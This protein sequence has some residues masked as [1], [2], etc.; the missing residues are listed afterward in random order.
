LIPNLI[1]AA[2][3]AMV[4]PPISMIATA[5]ISFKDAGSASSLFNMMRNLGG[6]I[7]IATVSTFVTNREKFHSAIM[8]PQVSLLDPGT[9][10]RLAL[11]QHYFEAHGLSDPQAAQHE[12]IIAVGRTIAGQASYLAYGDA[13]ALLGCGMVLATAAALLLRKPQGAAAPGGH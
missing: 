12:A 4:F 6:A 7:G 2:G 5:G 10:Q 8:T 11:L 1:R 3:Q 13:F 9:R